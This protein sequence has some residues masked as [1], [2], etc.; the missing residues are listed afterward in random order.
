[1][2]DEPSREAVAHHE[3]GHF[4]VGELV[5]ERH[6]V[7]TIEPRPRRVGGVRLGGVKAY[8]DPFDA[9]Q[10]DARRT[11]AAVVCYFAGPAAQRRFDGSARPES[12]AE[13]AQAL[14]AAIGAE[15][16]E[17]ALR[18]EAERLVAV[19][20]AAVT[21]LAEALLRFGTLSE[22]A[23]RHEVVTAIATPLTET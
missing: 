7:V 5:G 16:E 17:A 1:V 9:P 12:D 23:A 13:S 2:S 4:V 8:T 14:L 10:A 11:R 21:K 19:H 20:W 18:A 22:R 15:A 3:S 6:S